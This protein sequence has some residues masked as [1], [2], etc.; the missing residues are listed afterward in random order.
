MQGLF[1]TGEPFNTSEPRSGSDRVLPEALKCKKKE[2][3][4]LPKNGR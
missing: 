4:I 1:Q 3:N 2:L